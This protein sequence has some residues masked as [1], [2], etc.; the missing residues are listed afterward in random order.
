MMESKLND[1]VQITGR[2]REDTDRPREEGYVKTEAEIEMMH[3]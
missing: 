2:K 3:L 1:G